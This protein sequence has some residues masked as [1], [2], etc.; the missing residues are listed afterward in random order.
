MKAQRRAQEPIAAGVR[1]SRRQ[2]GHLA[3]SPAAG[4]GG[5][6]IFAASG[7]VTPEQRFQAANAD[8]FEIPISASVGMAGGS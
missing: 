2:R 6:A 7:A 4:H 1:V 3:T 5:M 8:R